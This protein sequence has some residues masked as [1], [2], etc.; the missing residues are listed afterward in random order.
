MN[1]VKIVVF[2]HILIIDASG[3]NVPSLV[4]IELVHSCIEIIYIACLIFESTV[5]DVKK[6][7][8]NVKLCLPVFWFI[9]NINIISKKNKG[10]DHFPEI[11][12]L[13]WNKQQKRDIISG[14]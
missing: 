8:N 13:I 12:C 6:K 11:L 14:L 3:D 7:Y 2:Y 4:V 9:N 1:I 10:F 5:Y